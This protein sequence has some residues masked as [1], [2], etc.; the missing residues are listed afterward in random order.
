VVPVLPAVE[1]SPTPGTTE[2]APAPVVKVTSSEPVRQSKSKETEFSN[3]PAEFRADVANLDSEVAS[4]Q[5]EKAALDAP[6][7]RTALRW[8][9]EVTGEATFDVPEADAHRRFGELLRDGVLLCRLVN[10][11]QPG[12]VP[13]PKPSDLAFKQLSN[14][15]SFTR[16][17][18]KLGLQKRE[19]FDAQDLH[20]A[21]DYR[22]CLSCL[23]ALS[24]LAKAKIPA[25]QGPYLDSV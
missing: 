11:I 1:Q 18:Q 4:K 24:R 16:A 15:T 3:T 6:K 23:H 25:F 19:C 2:A 5:R 10:A 8:I 9:F 12:A 14:I 13:T 22:P 7:Y 21:I 17:C 20:Q